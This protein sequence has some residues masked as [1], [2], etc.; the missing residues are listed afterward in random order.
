MR[1]ISEYSKRLRNKVKREGAFNSFV[2]I[3]LSVESHV[4]DKKYGVDT[5]RN[6]SL[7]DLGVTNEN[8]QFGRQYQPILVNHLRKILGS[9]EFTKDDVLVDFGSGKGRVLLISSMFPF[10]RVVGVEFS[11]RLCSIARDNVER[12]NPPRKLC[13]I[14]IH[15]IDAAEYAIKDDETIF[16]FFNPFDRVVMQSVINNIEVSYSRSPRKIKLVYLNLK[17][18]ELK[19]NS[20][21]FR[22]V[23]DSELHGLP[24]QIYETRD[25][26]SNF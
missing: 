8:V 21:T 16:F 10:K 23:T 25:R 22:L 6:I 20:R 14:E 17:S 13:P 18:Q 24:F 15:C 4:F 1:K 3:C 5:H 19:S 9:I 2:Q 7:V 11:D 26:D 12:F